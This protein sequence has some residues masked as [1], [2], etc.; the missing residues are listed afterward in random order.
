MVTIRHAGPHD[1]AFLL[2]M[3]AEA[4]SWDRPPGS[5][6]RALEDVLA[7]PS[8]HYA[9]G[10]PRA[11]DAGAIAEIDGR[12]VGACWFRYLTADDPGWGYVADDVPEISI[13]VREDARGRGIGTCLLD[14]TI[15][16][17]RD[18]GLRALSLSVSD[19]N[20]ARRIYDRA[21][22]VPVDRDDEATTML[23]TLVD[24]D[25]HEQP[26]GAP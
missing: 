20:H 15:A 3:L 8:A 10:W 18:R 6:P 13:A 25:G 11:G 17:A 9:D 1:A 23:L 14:E 16:L 12:M 5:P 4:A 7:G 21:G 22:F 2:E 24:P 19:G 26:G